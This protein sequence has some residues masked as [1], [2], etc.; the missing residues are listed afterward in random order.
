MLGEAEPLEHS[1]DALADL[2]TG[3]SVAAHREGGVREA[4]VGMM[5]CASGLLKTKPTRRRSCLG[6]LTESIPCAGMSP[7]VGR[8]RR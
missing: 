5:I 1:G 4:T 6:C 2:D 7:A 8:L 3:K